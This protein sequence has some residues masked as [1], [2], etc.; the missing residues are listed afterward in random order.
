ML[1]GLKFVF[2]CRRIPQPAAAE[3]VLDPSPNALVTNCAKSAREFVSGREVVAKP[4]VSGGLIE[5]GRRYAVYTTPI[6]INDLA[7]GAIH[8]APVIFQERIP[9]AFDLRVTIV[10]SRVFA[11]R[12]A[13]RDR[14][15]VAD[16][17]GFRVR[18]SRVCISERP[19]FRAFQAR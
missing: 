17:R 16:W 2:L 18:L 11:T 19:R 1:G 13:A 14:G 8:A 7:D 12:I 9:N 4:V 15:S 3:P 5:A 6:T 10:G